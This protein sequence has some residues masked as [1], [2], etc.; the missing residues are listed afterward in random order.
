V[1]LTSRSALEADLAHSAA[2]GFALDRQ[3][4]ELGA[5]C[6]AV[7]IP[8]LLVVAAVGFSGPAQRL[9]RQA[10]ERYGAAL[11]R[12]AAVVAARLA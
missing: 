10:L 1:T 11:I 6:V 2:P 4:N 12:G 9:P 3:E 8:A 7:A 5:R